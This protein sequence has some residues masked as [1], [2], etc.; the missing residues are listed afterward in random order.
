MRRCSLGVIGRAEGEVKEKNVIYEAIVG[1]DFPR[2]MADRKIKKRMKYKAL[3]FY[4][5]W[6]Y[7]SKGMQIL[8]GKYKVKKKKKNVTRKPA[9]AGKVE[10]SPDTKEIIYLTKL[11]H[12]KGEDH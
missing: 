8:S 2:L 10:S 5:W 4:R 9:I 6:N 7:P 11:I 12:I 1:E 3:K